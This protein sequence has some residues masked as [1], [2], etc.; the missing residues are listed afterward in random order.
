MAHHTS[1]AGKLVVLIGGGGFLGSHLA[2]ELLR[3][4]A[5]LRIA[6]RHPETAFRLRPLADLGQIQFVRC[7]VKDRAA[8]P[9]RCTGP[10]R[11]CTSSAPSPATSRRCRPT[12]PG[13]P[14]RRPRARARAAFAYVS[15]IGADAG[16]D[17]G[18]AATKAEGEAL[19]RAAF[20]QA[21][22]VRPSVLFGEDDR[23]VNLFAALIAGAAGAAGVR[24][25]RP[26]CSR[27]SSTTPPRRSPTALADP[28][29]H[30]GKT[31]ELAG[32]EVM[33]VEESAPPHCR[34]AGARARAG[35]GARRAGALF[36]ALP[37]TP[38]NP[39][40][41]KLLQ[42]GYG[43]LGRAAR[44]R[45]ARRPAEAARAVPR[46]VDDA[47]PQAR[48]LRGH[49]RSVVPLSRSADRAKPILPRLR[50]RCPRSGR[51]RA[52]ARGSSSGNPEALSY[53]RVPVMF[54]QAL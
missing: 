36:A 1:L 18:Y 52:R 9:R 17:S 32:P 29:K 21:T 50:R 49:Q 23:F 30:G 53:T 16:S 2:Q 33:T 24:R 19:V 47:L 5:R 46:P 27:C 39:D 22:V 34:R 3:S 20:P 26:G 13:S 41:W 12:A 43:R 40:Q 10:R 25:R 14:P 8:W 42:R 45:R 44:D 28:A 11:R 54:A 37:G 15:A 7:N 51:R 31:Y 6:E 38:M 35:R 4:G 48:A